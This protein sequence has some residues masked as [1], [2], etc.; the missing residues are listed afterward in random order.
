MAGRLDPVNADAPADMRVL[1]ERLRGA[2]SDAGYQVSRIFAADAGVSPATLSDALGGAKTPSWDT[3]AKLLKACDIPPDARWK[4]LW[5]AAQGAERQWRGTAPAESVEVRRPGSLSIRPPIGGLPAHVRGRVEVLDHIVDLVGRPEPV[6][7][8][9]H[10]LGGCGKTTIAL[11]VARRAPADCPVFWVS[12][13][14]RGGLIEGMKQVAREVGVPENQVEHAWAGHGSAMD[15]LWR[16]LDAAPHP[17]LLVVDNA[18][19]PHLLA[20]AGGVPGDGTGWVRPSRAGTTVVTSRVGTREVWGS[21]ARLHHVDVLGEEDA[22]DV[23]IDLA[24]HAGERSAA[25]ALAERLGGLP[26]ALRS[27]GTYLGRTSRGGGLLRREAGRPARAATF[28]AYRQAL[29]DFAPDLLDEG[30]PHLNDV[31]RR[32]QLH[33]GLVSRTWEMSLDLLETQGFVHARALMRLMSCFASAPLP[34]DLLDEAV[35]A[36]A[37]S[38]AVVLSDVDLSLEALVDQAMLV[39]TQV[40]GLTGVPDHVSEPP[41]ACLLGH[42]LVLEAVASRLRALPA[43]EQAPTWRAAAR[44]ITRAATPAPEEAENWTWWRLLLPHVAALVALVPEDDEAVF[45]EVLQCAVRGYAY[46]PFSD[47]VEDAERY[48]QLVLSRAR[49]L[50]DDDPVL[51]AARHRAALAGTGPIAEREAEFRRIAAV[52]TEVLGPDHPDTLVTRHEAAWTLDQIEGAA[53]A[54]E[55]MRAIARTRTSLLGAAN[56]YTLVSR[57]VLIGM[58]TDLGRHEEAEAEIRAAIA[59]CH[60]ERGHSDHFTLTWKAKL[61]RKLIKRGETAVALDEFQDAWRGPVTPHSARGEVAAVLTLLGLHSE[62]ALEYR[63]LLRHLRASGL[64]RGDRYRTVLRAYADC[65]RE[66]KLVDEAIAAYDEDIARSTRLDEHHLK[67]RLDRA[68]ALL[69]ARR[70]TEAE[71]ALDELLTEPTGDP[72]DPLFVMSVRRNRGVALLNLRK[73]VEAEQEWRALL[74]DYRTLLGPDA[75]ELRDALTYHAD[76]LIRLSREPEALDVLAELAELRTSKFGPGDPSVLETSTTR[77]RL[78]LRL[79]RVTV[80]EA[81]AEFA[82]L[83]ECTD[84]RTQELCSIRLGREVAATR[85]RNGDKEGAVEE[86]RSLDGRCVAL[87]KH[88]DGQLTRVRWSLADLLEGLDR[89]AEALAVYRACLEVEERRLESTHG[90]LLSTRWGIVRMRLRA[91]EIDAE[92]ATAEFA[93][94]V[95]GYAAFYGATDAATLWL[96]KELAE[97]RH[98]AGDTAGAEAEVRALIDICR[99]HH[100]PEDAVTRET[101]WRLSWVLLS[102]DRYADALPVLEECLAAELAA[103]PPDARAPLRT[104]R[105]IAQCRHELGLATPGETAEVYRAVLPG[106]VEHDGPDGDLPIT[107][108]AALAD[109]AG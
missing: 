16:H 52:Q 80:D 88:T 73:N 109:L 77:I 22:A 13:S 28:D 72:L 62:A 108:R 34:A 44:L 10:G 82:D 15:L 40:D 87:G 50:P 29:G 8:V 63:E 1:A 89:P 35:L 81:L 46:M 100:K 17:W 7:Q 43:A 86:L 66:Q 24:G 60:R 42:R 106:L 84:P 20:S 67:L 74:A 99:K 58:L 70:D 6:L 27:A 79:A 21:R 33:R 90:D 85:V 75:W 97:T 49:A 107:I 30:V 104:R 2:M 69:L 96:R 23:L 19:E 101:L 31:E 98:A 76:S 95:P 38:R 25:R 26:L 39:V 56:P 3:V 105:R 102:E 92:Q 11:E 55:E 41:L 59:D 36:E 4:R 12:A 103:L 54:V 94:L 93:D 65:L 78:R 71:A 91:E 57:S 9:L 53:G 18:D 5:E 68:K 51:L 64:D 14:Q 83:P 32:E 47:D 37:A 61:V 45:R 48:S